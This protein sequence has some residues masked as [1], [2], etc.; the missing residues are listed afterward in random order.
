[1]KLKINEYYE[2]GQ[3]SLFFKVGID[4]MRKRLRG[5]VKPLKKLVEKKGRNNTRHIFANVYLLGDVVELM[6]W[7]F[8]WSDK[9]ERD[10]N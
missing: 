7:K 2:V 3:L 6:K 5:K 9:N 4:T 10:T 1:M 8:G